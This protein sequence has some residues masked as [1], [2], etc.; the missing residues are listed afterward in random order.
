VDDLLADWRIL[1]DDKPAAR[2]AG[3]DLI[4][5]WSEPHRTYH[6][7]D[8]L[9]A[10]LEAIDVLADHAAD[11]TA[12][13]LAAWFHDA[14]YDGRPGD[15]E[16]ASATLA[17]DTLRSLGI[18][19][20]RVAEVSRLVQL[21]VSHDPSSG[22]ANGA[23]LCDAD[24]AVLGGDPNQYATYASNIRAEYAHVPDRAF[25]SGRAEVLR[26]LLALDPLYRTSTARARWQDA[27]RHNLTTE[28]ALLSAS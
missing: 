16:Q 21:T 1:V 11:L 10:V 18:E 12:V 7:V 19:K 14:V 4:S 27:A 6:N 9:R 26:R 13:R 5:R 2:S 3:A 25:R 23:V 24:L 8:H 15:D 20:H 28:L 17:A 22:D